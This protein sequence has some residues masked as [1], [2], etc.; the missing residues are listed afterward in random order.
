[1]LGDLLK[2]VR[3]TR[4]FENFHPASIVFGSALVPFTPGGPQCEIDS[5]PMTSLPGARKRY[6]WRR[7]AIGVLALVALLVVA[8]LW[9][10]AH[11]YS[12]ETSTDIAASPT[13]VW[14]VLTDLDAYP[15]W[16]PTLDGFSGELTEGTEISFTD[17]DA[18]VTATVLEVTPDR[19]IRWE[20]HAGI[21]GILDGERSFRLEELP[22][23]GTRFT[24]SGLYRGVAVLFTTGSLHDETAPSFHELNAAVRERAELAQKD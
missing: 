14:G 17:G 24:Q 3:D 22:D 9:Q 12:I 6:D 8:A 10:R 23:G 1:V 19:E 16:S 4:R 11:P 20:S 13:E 5:C 15:D 21:M 2:G 18:D 7:A